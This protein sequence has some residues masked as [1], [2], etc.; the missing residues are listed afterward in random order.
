MTLLQVFFKTLIS[1]KE[2]FTQLQNLCVKTYIKQ[3]LK[4]DF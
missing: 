2:T 1:T 3:N 4:P